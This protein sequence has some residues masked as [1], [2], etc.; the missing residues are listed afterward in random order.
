MPLPSPRAQCYELSPRGHLPLP[1]HRA[2]ESRSSFPGSHWLEPAHGVRAALQ[3]LGAGTPGR[4]QDSPR[5]SP[6]LASHL[7]PEPIPLTGCCRKVPPKCTS[8]YIILASP[9]LAWFPLLSGCSSSL[10]HKKQVC[11]RPGP[12]GLPALP[13]PPPPAPSSH[14]TKLPSVPQ[15]HQVLACPLRSLTP[16]TRLLAS[17]PSQSLL[18]VAS[19]SQLPTPR[20]SADA[21]PLSF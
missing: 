21:H 15:T 8:D 11:S 10:L 18:Q 20:A 13:T 12:T 17:S 1:W 7:T 3:A 16:R 6:L 19:F 2:E 9:S 5:C 14:C 4:P